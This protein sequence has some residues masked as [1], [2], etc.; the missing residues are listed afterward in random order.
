L[1]KTFKRKIVILNA[2]PIVKVWVEMFV[3]R[4]IGEGVIRSTFSLGLGEDNTLKRA[5]DPFQY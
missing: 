5:F 2:K 1:N 4:K 3:V